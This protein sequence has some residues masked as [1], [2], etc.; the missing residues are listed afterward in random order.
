MPSHSVWKTTT[1][2]PE[3]TIFNSCQGAAFPRPTSNPKLTFCLHPFVTEPMVSLLTFF[4]I[5]TYLESNWEDILSQDFPSALLE[6]LPD[7]ELALAPLGC[8]PVMNTIPFHGE[9]HVPLIHSLSK[10]RPESL[11]LLSVR[12]VVECPQVAGSSGTNHMAQTNPPS[13]KEPF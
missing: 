6:L 7:E 5:I 3:Q 9:W 12:L 2:M 8:L 13:A 4:F 11:S 1:G 10:G